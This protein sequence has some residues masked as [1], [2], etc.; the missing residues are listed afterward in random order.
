MER[1]KEREILS[2]R[3]YEGE[4]GMYKVDL[5]ELWGHC[6]CVKLIN[7]CYLCAVFMMP[8]LQIVAGAQEDIRSDDARRERFQ[9]AQRH[10]Q[11]ALQAGGDVSM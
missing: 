8:I 1:E 9:Q 5:I 10:R 11:A 2:A 3:G 7:K 4:Y 6:C